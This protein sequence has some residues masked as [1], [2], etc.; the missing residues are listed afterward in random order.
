MRKKIKYYSDP[1]DFCSFKFGDDELI[2]YFTG[3]PISVGEKIRF[4][5]LRNTKNIFTGTVVDIFDITG[6]DKAYKIKLSKK[7]VI[8]FVFRGE[9]EIIKSI[10]K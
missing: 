9:N 3:L 7:G 2:H 10:S 5:S 4:T 8:D 1:L 6:K